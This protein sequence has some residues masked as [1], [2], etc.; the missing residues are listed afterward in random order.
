MGISIINKAATAY[1]SSKFFSF[2]LLTVLVPM[3]TYSQSCIV[4]GLVQKFTH[5]VKLMYMQHY[6]CTL[7]LKKF[8]QK[9][10]P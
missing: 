3:C 8:E 4:L 2:R 9:S 10:Y 5:A 6:V 1:I 7:V